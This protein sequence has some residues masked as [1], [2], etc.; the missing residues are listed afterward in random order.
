[1]I[2]ACNNRLVFLV[3]LF[4]FFKVLLIYGF[5]HQV[6]YS[7]NANKRGHCVHRIVV[8]ERRRVNCPLGHYRHQ[9]GNRQCFGLDQ[10]LCLGDVGSERLDEL[11]GVHFRQEI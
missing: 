11:G 6:E 3:F 4:G 9:F 2:I 10:S 7:S 1:M 8:D 5:H